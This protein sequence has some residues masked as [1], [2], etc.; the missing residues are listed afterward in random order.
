MRRSVAWDYV[1]ACPRT[2]DDEPC[3]GQ[4]RVSGWEEYDPP[5]VTATV[6]VCPVC[7][8]ED[9]RDDELPPMED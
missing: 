6:G 7:G 9:I 3:A 1:T 5:F 2:V 4:V 8:A